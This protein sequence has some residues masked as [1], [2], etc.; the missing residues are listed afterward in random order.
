MLTRVD[1]L[2]RCGDPGRPAVTF[3]DETL[4]YGELSA[5]VSQV[6]AGL[7]RL[8]LCRGER[9]V[10]YLEKRIE[11]VVA[12]FAVSAAGGVVVP[13]NPLFKAKQVGYV[14]NDCGARVVITT[15]ERY[16]MLRTELRAIESLRHVVL[17]GE[18]TADSVRPASPGQHVTAWS[19]LYHLGAT[20]TAPA[21]GGDAVIDM[22]VAAMLYT[23]G[24]TGSPKG[25]VLSHRNVLAG[26]QSVAK[27]LE[28]T[29][30]D[31]ILAVLPLSFD[32]GFSQLTTSFIAGAHVV[33][34]NYLLPTEVLRLCA[35]HKITG[36]TC[37]PPLWL[38]LAAQTWSVD[39]TRHLRYF[40]NTGGRMPRS[41]LERLRA[42][43]SNARPY[44]MYGL[45]EAFRSTYLDPAE[46]DRR[47]D[48]IG[49]AIPNAE[50]LVVR[51]DGTEC[52]PGEEGEIV[53]RGSLVALGYWND[54][55]RTA[56]R[57]R[58]FPPTS[59]GTRAEIAVWSG[60]LAHRD[61]EGFIYFVGRTDDMIKTSGYR[62]SPTEIEEV[63]Y[64]TG[65]VGEAAAF[66]AHDD[67]LGQHVVLA[68]TGPDGGHCDTDTLVKALENDLPRY[69]VPHRVFVCTELPRSGNGKFDRTKLRRMVTG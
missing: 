13:V 11:T 57:F 47:P 1:D 24:S 33:L 27:Y 16:R 50:V 63:A 49:K 28:H 25:V 8:G 61:A 53:H 9:V 18:Q 62:V 2:L 55:Q 38:Q 39:A 19:Q 40:A 6:A 31:V 64:A 5:R 54:P 36:L 44:L 68:V 7:G 66:G 43:F 37:V 20:A 58:P 60:D 4:S 41:T 30:D 48:S 23:S 35:T 51:P 69:M 65:L 12:L 22:D 21:S 10:V 67:R 59:N 45:T 56:E 26:A 3:K 15:R 32:T 17:V 34:V 14:A 29:S 52:E 42:L 46:V